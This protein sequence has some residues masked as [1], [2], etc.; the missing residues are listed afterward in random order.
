MKNE[1]AMN[2]PK[3]CRIWTGDD[4]RAEQASCG[5]HNPSLYLPRQVA[6]YGEHKFRWNEREL[7]VLTYWLLQGLLMLSSYK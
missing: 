5:S 6:T 2:Q 3:A 4:S 7:E 1:M